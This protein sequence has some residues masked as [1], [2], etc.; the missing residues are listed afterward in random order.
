MSNGDAIDFVHEMHEQRV[1]FGTGSARTQLSDEVHRLKSRRVL[2][3]A[4]KGQRALAE[5]LTRGLPMVGV[6]DQVRMHVPI[7]VAVAARRQADDLRAD[8]LLSIGGGST[9][10]TAKAVALTSGLPVLAVPTTYAGSEATPVWGV[11][12]A[13]RKATGTDARVLPRTVVYD[14]ELSVTLPVG[15]SVASGLNALAHGVDSQWAPQADPI[16]RALALE[17]VRALSAGLRLVHADPADLA[18]RS[19]CLY[20]CYLAALG[21]ASA[22]AG[23][24]HKICH[25]LGGSWDLPHAET[26]AVVLPHV[27]AWNAASAPEAAAAI[28]AALG[29]KKALEGLLDLEDEL[30]APT[31]LRELGLPDS[32]LPQAARLVVE[33]APEDNPRP[34]DATLAEELLRG[35]WLGRTALRGQRRL[36]K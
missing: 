22:G 31:S 29:T 34:V 27:L 1:V 21:F 35:A 19:Q 28:A 30:E 14:P 8:L 11:T 13:G 18:G 6:V 32:A 26:H 24:H 2:L 10:G 3:V 12:D 5:E 20:G 23:L 4:A 15:L 36:A 9:L 17:G 16:N 33:A 25:V 7:E